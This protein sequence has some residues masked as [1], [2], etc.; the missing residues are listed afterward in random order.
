MLPIAKLLAFACAVVF[1]GAFLDSR[2]V[3]AAGGQQGT[4]DNNCH[5]ISTGYFCGSQK[6]FLW[7]YKSCTT[8]G[9]NQKALCE[10]GL[11]AGQNCL[12]PKA[13]P[14]ENLAFYG[15]A[16][17]IC[18]CNDA[19]NPAVVEATDFMVGNGQLSLGLMVCQ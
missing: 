6:G 17:E 8:C 15:T 2:E 1:L 16:T 14:Q 12:T 3:A 4:C 13:G 18:D 5:N 9:P 10:T 19:S 11:A 7:T